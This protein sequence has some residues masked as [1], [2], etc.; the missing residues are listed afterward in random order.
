MFRRGRH[1]VFP[2]IVGR[3]QVEVAVKDVTYKVSQDLGQS[4]RTGV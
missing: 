2:S 1:A 3:I 4:G